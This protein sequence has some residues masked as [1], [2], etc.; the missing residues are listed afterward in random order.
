MLSAP[1]GGLASRVLVRFERA[2]VFLM[3]HSGRD[4]FFKATETHVYP[5]SRSGIY[6][7]PV[8]EWSRRGRIVSFV[9]G[10]LPV[11]G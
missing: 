4:I 6:G 9:A 10:P 7:F 3:R 2:G 1:G 8:L 11:S 5:F